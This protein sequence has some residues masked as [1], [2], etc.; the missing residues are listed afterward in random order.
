M[1]KY[2][3]RIPLFMETLVE[4]TIDTEIELIK[5]L[6]YIDEKLTLLN[7]ETTKLDLKERL[8]QN[9]IQ[10]LI[11]NYRM[12]KKRFEMIEDRRIVTDSIKPCLY[13]F[14]SFRFRD[15]R[16]NLRMRYF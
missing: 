3:V 16:Y 4:K 10:E 13:N 8:E 1:L 5:E 11:W 12:L 9:I 6:G 2:K 15:L 14:F 7:E